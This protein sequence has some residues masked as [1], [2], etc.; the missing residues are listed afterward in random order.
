MAMEISH[1]WLGNFSSKEDY[2]DY[3]EEIY[4]EDDDAPIN[5]FAADQKVGFYDMD[6][7]ES[8]FDDSQDLRRLV[9]LG[10]YSKDYIDDVIR[11][12]QLKNIDSANTFIIIDKNEIPT[13]ISI[14]NDGYSLMYLGEYKC[15]TSVL[16]FD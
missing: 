4:S 6:W 12:A 9:S 14:K 10:S 15:D 13:P 1:I 2:L 3:M 7:E 11:D 8:F 16:E 5:K